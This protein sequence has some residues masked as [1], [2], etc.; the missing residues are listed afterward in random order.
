M[1]SQSLDKLEEAASKLD[2]ARQ[3]L[4]SSEGLEFMALAGSD[5]ALNIMRQLDG[6][7]SDLRK[8]IRDN[9]N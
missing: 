3:V 9:E 7:A 2:E 8:T 4:L 5:H 1:S 6:A